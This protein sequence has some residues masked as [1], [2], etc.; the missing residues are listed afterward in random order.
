MQEYR[1]NTVEGVLDIERIWENRV[2][3]RMRGRCLPW[4]TL[5]RIEALEPGRGDGTAALV[6]LCAL[7]DKHQVR[8]SGIAEPFGQAVMNRK[9]LL[10]WYRKFDFK[11]TNGYYIDREPKKGTQNEAIR[12][13]LSRFVERT[14]SAPAPTRLHRP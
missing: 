7:S 14:V 13:Q 1:Q 5:E 9:Q 11:V 2:A 4:V 6:W 8:L 12:I 3:L 10:A